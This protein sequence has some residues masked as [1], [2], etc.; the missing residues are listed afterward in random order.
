MSVH[1][2][3]IEELEIKNNL[4]EVSHV[5]NNNISKNPNC[6]QKCELG[7]HQ[8][9]LQNNLKRSSTNIGNKC[10]NDVIKHTQ[11]IAS[12]M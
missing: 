1:Q 11:S 7:N 9:M 4:Q 6:F 8:V 5:S 10:L 3:P 2:F 12:L